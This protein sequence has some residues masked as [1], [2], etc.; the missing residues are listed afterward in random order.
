MAQKRVIFEAK[1]SEVLGTG[2]HEDEITL[3]FSPDHAQRDA[4]T[5]AQLLR[6]IANKVEEKYTAVRREPP[7][8]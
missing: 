8:D 7:E 1:I 3:N 4:L 6:E 5:V 2:E